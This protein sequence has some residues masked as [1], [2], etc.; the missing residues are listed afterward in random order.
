MM[1]DVNPGDVVAWLDDCGPDNRPVQRMGKVVGFTDVGGDCRLIVSCK[2]EGRSSVIRPEICTLMRRGDPLPQSA[3]VRPA[4]PTSPPAK[5][6]PMTDV[7][8]QL[9]AR[10]EETIGA[11][12]E[13]F[14][15]VGAALAAIRN[16][17]L[18]RETDRTFE[19]YCRR[20]WGIGRRHAN[21]LVQS[22]E[23]VREITETAA[24]PDGAHGPQTARQA[25]ELARVPEGERAKAWDQT[26]ERTGKAQPT[27]A[28]IRAT[29]ADMYPPDGDGSRAATEVQAGASRD[30]DTYER[31]VVMDRKLHDALR[32]LKDEAARHVQTG[33]PTPILDCVLAQGGDEP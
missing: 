32:V 18:Y 20:R 22:A 31:R 14:Y 10:Y 16:E 26:R 24:D 13:T 1:T 21:R 2:D 11:G 23:V 25:R 6:K 3:D 5:A 19:E 29:V 33:A 8:R 9:L 4:K 28:E 12:L 30:G 7:D 27:G 15:S 17:R